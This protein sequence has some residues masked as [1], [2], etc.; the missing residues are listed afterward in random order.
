ME[1]I[2]FFVNQGLLIVAIDFIIVALGIYWLLKQEEK[3][4]G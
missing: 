2:K 4:N 3:K 1:L